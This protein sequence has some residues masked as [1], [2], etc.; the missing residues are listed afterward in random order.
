[1][2]THVETLSRLRVNSNQEAVISLRAE[3]GL[4]FMLSRLYYSI[5]RFFEQEVL[6]YNSF[7]I[8]KEIQVE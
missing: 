6:V 7:L 2:A 4:Q 8:K 5:D 3:T 1:M